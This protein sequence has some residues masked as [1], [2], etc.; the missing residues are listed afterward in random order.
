MIENYNLLNNPNF[1]FTTKKLP[2]VEFFA[3]T[4]TWPTISI[5]AV[6]VPTPRGTHYE[7]G[8]GI[9][10]TELNIDFLVD[11]DM[12]NY[13]EL[14]SWIRECSIPPKNPTPYP[15][16]QFFPF[17]DLALTVLDNSMN[18]LYTVNYINAFPVF[19]GSMS[20]DSSIDQPIPIRCS[21]QFRYD[22]FER[23]GDSVY[24]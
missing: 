12:K 13:F 2:G 16:G 24:D 19:L 21:V 7:P 14:Y 8:V 6:D 4:V 22:H 5:G 17:S 1:K 18:P 10:Y 3:T 20:F 9:Q 11:E 15:T 23:S